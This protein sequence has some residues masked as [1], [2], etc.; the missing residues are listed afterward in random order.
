VHLIT[1]HLVIPLLGTSFC[2]IR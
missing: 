1:K 2:C